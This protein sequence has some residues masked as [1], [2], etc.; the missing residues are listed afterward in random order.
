M[1]HRI[2]LL[3]LPL[4]FPAGLAAGEDGRDNRLAIARNGAG[5]PV[6]RGT[7]LAGRLRRAWRKRWQSTPD[8]D[9]DERVERF[10][11]RA[12][13]NDADSK[14]TASRLR[15][16]DVVL[17]ISRHAQ[18]K[19]TVIE[20]THHLRDRHTGVVADGG[21]F[22]LE[23]CPPGTTGQV[24]LWLRDMDDSPTESLGFLA[25]IV[26]LF[27]RGA[28]LGGKSARG[29]GAAHLNGQVGYRAYDLKDADQ[30]ARY[31][32][33]QLAWRRAPNVFPNSDKWDPARAAAAASAVGADDRLCVKITLGIPRG[34]D[35]LV[36]D[37][38]GL[39]CDAEPQR[40]MSADGRL[41]WR[42]PGSSLR[43]LFR[44]WFTR[45]AAREDARRPAAGERPRVAD[46]VERRERVATGKASPE[47]ALTG[48]NLGWAFL[49]QDQ[50][51]VG[52][53]H[54]DCPVSQL[55]GTLFQKSR[56]HI[57]DAYSECSQPAPGEGVELRE[58]QLRKHVAI[59]AISGGAVENLLF[60]NSALVGAASSAA[61]AQPGRSPRFEVKI[62][63]EAPREDEARWLAKTLRALD[64]GVLRVGSSK[65]SGRLSLVKPPEAAGP[66]S[67]LLRAVVPYFPSK[68]FS[69]S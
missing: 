28:T 63:I 48:D 38:Q 2:H 60:E 1:P 27:E 64:V 5:E 30:H 22:S 16:S 41:L 26:E 49:P 15:V 33:D 39:R 18:H 7:S 23:A 35:L 54:T 42:L 8:V 52:T 6:L 57:S 29:I 25:T 44:G 32:D 43:G 34:Q 20:R 37:G 9:V 66:H 17:N 45:L 65:S 36:A 68:Q 55:F 53:A 47:E 40:V 19:A 59:D 56:I 58:E 46:R 24:V 4:V 14:D 13:D 12:A 31:L 21:L 10:F 67:A 62:Q 51:K 69:A 50:R 61:G 11:G 3:T